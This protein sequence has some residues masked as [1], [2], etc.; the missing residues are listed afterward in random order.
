MQWRQSILLSSPPLAI[1]SNSPP[2]PKINSGALLSPQ[3]SLTWA[4]TG[5]GIDQQRRLF[6]A[7]PAAGGPIA[8]TATSGTISGRRNL[9]V[10]G[11][12][13][14]FISTLYSLPGDGKV[15]YFGNNGGGQTG[16]DTAHDIAVGNA[17]DYTTANRVNWAA[18]GYST[19]VFISRGFLAFD[20]SSLPANA[21]I[22]SATLGVFVTGTSDSLN[23]GNDFV[24]V[25]QGL[26]ASSASL[27]GN[28]YN[29]AGNAVDNPTEGSNRIDITGITVNSYALWTPNSNG[30]RL[31]K[32]SGGISQFAVRE[33]HRR[34]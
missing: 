25:T 28:D 31:D 24:T 2:P 12:G 21:L 11:T 6:T 19:N 20:T 26:Q 17:T 18:S 33:G 15:A 5:G 27:T 16:W 14:T 30:P 34:P 23:D 7:G 4:V 8:I 9:N 13:N 32:A 29:K 1:H 10:T 22:T 3:P